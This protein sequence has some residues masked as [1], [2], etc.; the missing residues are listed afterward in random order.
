[1]INQ[2]EWTQYSEPSGAWAATAEGL[3]RGST[4]Q[5]RT[6]NLRL[7]WAQASQ[8]W[9]S[10]GGGDSWEIVQFHIHVEIKLQHG[11][12]FTIYCYHIGYIHNSI[13]FMIQPKTIPDLKSLSGYL[14]LFYY[15]IRKLQMVCECKSLSLQT[16]TLK[17][18]LA[19]KTPC[20]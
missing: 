1:M 3:I 13:P 4:R 8:K 11:F 12:L 7:L 15:L 17:A 16:N 20:Y 2:R 18:K 10:W 9:D 6:V 5:P 19:I 14:C